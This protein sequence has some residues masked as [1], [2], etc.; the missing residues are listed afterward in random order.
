M[1]E[2]I[3]NPS[4]PEEIEVYAPSIE[5][6]LSVFDATTNT[7][8]GVIAALGQ[9]LYTEAQA[10][11]LGNT[12]EAVVLLA[13]DTIKAI[14]ETGEAYEEG[15]DD[16]YDEG[17]EDGYEEAVD[18]LVDDDDYIFEDEDD[19]I[20]TQLFYCDECDKINDNVLISSETGDKLCPICGGV[21][22]AYYLDD[23]DDEHGEPKD[24][25]GTN[26]GE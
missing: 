1:S 13:S 2:N 23:D 3:T 9:D 6:I 5:A 16:G 19:E 10:T 8:D 4:V 22:S 18:D 24:G 17:A 14:L 15:W 21:V 25:G 26:N 12:A 20:P 11:A 7:L